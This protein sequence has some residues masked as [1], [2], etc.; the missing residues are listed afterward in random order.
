MYTKRKFT[1]PMVGTV[2]PQRSAPFPLFCNLPSAFC[3]TKGPSFR[4]F[5]LFSLTHFAASCPSKNTL[6]L[7]KN[8]FNHSPS[9]SDP[10]QLRA[11]K[12]QINPEK[13]QLRAANVNA[14]TALKLLVPQCLRSFPFTCPKNLVQLTLTTLF[15]FV[16]GTPFMECTVT[17][18]GIMLACFNTIA[19]ALFEAAPDLPVQFGFSFQNQ[20]LDFN[21]SIGALR[22]P[23]YHQ[24]IASGFES[25]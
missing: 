9:A 13:V 4:R 16:S 2:C 12:V 7:H 24:Q 5:L 20:T 23:N 17:P 25:S 10:S 3:V 21:G 15:F 18:R 19:E 8:T 6:S 11:D 14:K 22:N 1:Q